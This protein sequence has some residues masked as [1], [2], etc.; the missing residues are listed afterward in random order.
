MGEAMPELTG[1]KSRPAP[2]QAGDHVP[3]KL[4]RMRQH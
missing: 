3:H 2:N 4:F 1:L